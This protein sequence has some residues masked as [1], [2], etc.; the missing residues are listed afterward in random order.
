ML[1]DDRLRIAS[2][3]VSVT[4]EISQYLAEHGAES[5]DHPHDTQG[6]A[7]AGN[8]SPGDRADIHSGEN[9]YGEGDHK[10]RNQRMQPNAGDDKRHQQRHTAERGQ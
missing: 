1:S 10:Q 8:S 6:V 3:I 5:D 7:S 9:A 4:P 2:A